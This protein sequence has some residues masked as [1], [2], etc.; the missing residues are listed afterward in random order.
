MASMAVA[1]RTFPSA[2]PASFITSSEAGSIK[3]PTQYGLAPVGSPTPPL[4]QRHVGGR[5]GKAPIPR[6][7]VDPHRAVP[8]ALQRDDGAGVEGDR[9]AGHADFFATRPHAVS[10]WAASAGV[11]LPLPPKEAM[12]VSRPSS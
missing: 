9:R 10:S 4:G 7:G 3:S 8:P 12:R 6:V 5:D 11:G 2:M 1:P